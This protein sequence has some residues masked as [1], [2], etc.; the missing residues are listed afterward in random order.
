MHR[1]YEFDPSVVLNPNV[2]LGSNVTIGSMSI[3][4]Q[5]LRGI[6]PGAVAVV[7]GADSVIRSHSVIYAGNVIGRGFHGGHGLFLREENRIG[8]H[9]S[10]GTKT[11]VE[12]H[13]QIGSGVR[14]H[15]QAF[16]PEYTVLEDGCWIGPN[17][18][19]TNADYPASQRAKDHLRAVRV[20]C[21]ARIG[22]NV[23]ILPGVVIG[24]GS[25]VGAGS[26][27]TRNVEPGT[28]VVGNPARII[29]RVDALVWPD[30]SA[31]YS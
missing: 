22:A 15:S 9:V 3:I 31:V 23:T 4:G 12:H 1:G 14:I 25:L 28:V 26:V 10:I 19:L 30:G 24:A 17:V 2:Q 29:K 8:D 7:I 13:V 5:P 16:I 21:R 20:C 6:L 11:I 18:V 27:V